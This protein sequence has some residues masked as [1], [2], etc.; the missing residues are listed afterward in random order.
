[1]AKSRLADSILCQCQDAQVE[2]PDAKRKDSIRRKDLH[3]RRRRNVAYHVKVYVSD[4]TIDIV[5]ADGE[6]CSWNMK[7]VTFSRSAVD[8]FMFELDD[9]RLY[10]LPV[11]PNAF[12]SDVVQKYSDVPVEPH[13]GWLRRRIEAAQADT[14]IQA[15]GYDS[16]DLEE[17]PPQTEGSRRD[18]AHRRRRHLH[19]W[20]E[21]IA[22]GVTTRRCVRCSQVSIDATGVTSSLDPT[23]ETV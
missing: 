12:L 11:D 14:S 19:E 17:T 10:F 8:R 18:P 1:M 22:V 13:R 9:E 20:Q 23:L 4:S 3:E 7:D 5:G 6:E 2:V 15:E 16:E 21:S